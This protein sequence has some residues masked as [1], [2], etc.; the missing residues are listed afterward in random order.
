MALQFVDAGAKTTGD[1]Q[2]AGRLEPQITAVTKPKFLTC[3]YSV[4]GLRRSYREGGT[5]K[6]EALDNN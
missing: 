2:Q 6:N 4:H 1:R 5:V 3:P